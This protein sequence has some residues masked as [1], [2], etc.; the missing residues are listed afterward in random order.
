MLAPKSVEEVRRLGCT[1]LFRWHIKDYAKIAAPLTCL[2]RK[3]SKFQWREVENHAFEQL[4]QALTSSPVLKKPD[5]ERPFEIHTDASGVAIGACLMQ[6]D[7]NGHLHPVA[8]FSRKLRD[9]EVRYPAIDA[10]ALA[11][12]EGVRAFDPYVYGCK[13]VI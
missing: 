10:E 1:G 5:F 12:V 9:A 13:F 6:G 2:T 3:D 11:V 7:D 8:Y 4:K